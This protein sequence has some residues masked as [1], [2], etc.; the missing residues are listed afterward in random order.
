MRYV[1][2]LDM[3]LSST[4]MMVLDEAGSIA[5]QESIASPRIG[6][7]VRQ[8]ITRYTTT[9]SAIYKRLAGMDDLH[10]ICIEGYSFGSKGQAVLDLAEFG[11]LIRAM[12]C[13]HFGGTPIHEVAPS[14]LKKWATGKG[15]FKGG[16]KT[17]M[18]VAIMNRYKVDFQTDD[19]FDAYGLARMAHQIGGFSEP[20]TT[21]QREAIDVVVNGRPKKVKNKKD[22]T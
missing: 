3:S 13:Q 12:L 1:V 10:C 21:F 22:A 6:G 16:G 15:A 7:S 2:G 4:G 8:R 18:V 11:G 17:P 14:N 20:E 19:E 9:V 5:H